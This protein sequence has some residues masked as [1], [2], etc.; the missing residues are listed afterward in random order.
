MSIHR[1]HAAWRRRTSDYHDA[2]SPFLS[3]LRD[4]TYLPC[5]EHGRWHLLH[6]GR[7]I[8]S[9]CK[10]WCSRKSRSSAICL[11]RAG[12]AG[13]FRMIAPMTERVAAAIT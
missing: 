11:E 1:R 6:W 4:N 3:V 13:T 10:H 12:E 5:C 7:R 2:A 8:T 9:G